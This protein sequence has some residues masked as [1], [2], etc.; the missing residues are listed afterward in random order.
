MGSLSFFIENLRNNRVTPIIPF[1]FTKGNL[2]LDVCTQFN[3][4]KV[5]NNFLNIWGSM[6]G[7]Y[8]IGLKDDP[9]IYYIGKTSN[10]RRRFYDHLQA[11]SHS[12]FHK[13]F[14]LT[15]I[16]S[17]YVA[18]IEVCPASPKFLASPNEIK[19]SSLLVRER[20]ADREK[21]FF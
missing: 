14:K 9:S 2:V 8:I 5:R 17:F 12:K 10:F 4:P 18:I 6:S 19:S 7:I 16:E 13:L 20:R 1:D 11:K 21:I 15:G 3:I